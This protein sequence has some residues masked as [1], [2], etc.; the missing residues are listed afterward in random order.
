MPRILGIACAQRGSSLQLGH[1]HLNQLLNFSGFD[2][3]SIVAMIQTTL[4]WLMFSPTS[5]T[6]WEALPML[7]AISEVAEDCCSTAEATD[8]ETSLIFPMVSLMPCRALT[9]PLVSCC[10]EAI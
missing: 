8:D 5:P 9:A 2:L 10:I 1:E 4:T 6:P 3:D 7:P